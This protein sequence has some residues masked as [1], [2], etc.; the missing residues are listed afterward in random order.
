[1]VRRN[2]EDLQVAADICASG[3]LITMIDK[4]YPLSET[5][6]ALRY[7]GDGYAKGKIVIQVQKDNAANIA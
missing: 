4:R 5:P 2:R 7:L 1:M 3:K 6:A